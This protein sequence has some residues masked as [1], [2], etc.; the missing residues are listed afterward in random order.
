MTAVQIL[1]FIGI[2][3]AIG[4]MAD[5]LF[6]KISFPDILIL[7]ALGYL[8]GPV[9]GIIDPTQIAPASQVIASLALVVILFNGGLD[10]K[11]SAVL[12][13]APRAVGLVVL[14]IGASMAATAAFTYYI[15]DW[16]LM[17]SLLLGAIIGGTSPS[18]VMPLVNRAKVPGKVS[19]VLNLESAFDGALVIVIALVILQL[20]TGG[21]TGNEA[22]MVGQAIAIRFSVGAAV[23]VGVGFFWLWI[24]TL[25]EGE[26]FDDILTLAVVFLVYFGVESLNGSGAIFALVFGVMLGNGVEVARFLRIKRTVEIHDV[27]RKFHSQMS[28]LIKTF[29][30]VYLGLVI[31]FDETSIIVLGVVLSLALLFVRYI[32]VLLTSIGN[33]T[34]LARQGFLTSMLPRGLSA[35]VVAEIVVVSGI[36]NASVYPGII[37]VVIVTTVVIASIGI[38]IFGRKAP[39]EDA[40]QLNQGSS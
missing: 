40:E 19:S 21:S 8:I 37:M 22:S 5:Y 34:L 4:F 1:G 39:E 25:L 3:L 7:L 20:M 24:L 15:L 12:S 6:R 27:M 31:S 16:Q 28:F 26:V 38:P 2:L 33:R 9:F 13:S 10:L 11:F 35:A 29:F 14:G 23:G 32:V 30:F 17:D 18:I 36:P